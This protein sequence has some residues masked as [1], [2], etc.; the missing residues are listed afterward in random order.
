MKHNREIYEYLQNQAFNWYQ[1][2]DQKAQ[3]VI[4]ITG[5]IIAILLTAITSDYEQ[6]T[7]LF[8]KGRIIIII[9]GI[10][11]II[12]VI[13]AI[14]SII[15]RGMFDRKTRTPIFFGFIANYPT[16]E[17]FFEDLENTKSEEIYEKL[18]RNTYHLSVNTKMKHQLVN[19]SWATFTIAMLLIVISVGW[20]L[21]P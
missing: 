15:S 3:V 1:Q 16:D 10:M 8:Y 6:F 11:L 19:I 12:T 18:I 2:A 7:K 21:T 14:W 4:G 5:V 9:V 20:L 17:A 13:L